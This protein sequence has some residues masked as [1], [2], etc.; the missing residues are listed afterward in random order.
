[1]VAYSFSEETAVITCFTNSFFTAVT[2]SQYIFYAS[3]EYSTSL[4]REEFTQF[5]KE[6]NSVILVAAMSHRLPVPHCHCHQLFQLV[7]GR[8]SS[9]FHREEL[10]DIFKFVIQEL[11]GI[12]KGMS[13]VSYQKSFQRVFSYADNTRSSTLRETLSNFRENFN[14]GFCHRLADAF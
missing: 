1:M 9:A 2:F 3:S 6:V 12:A 13:F 4:H 8:M 10:S 5:T 14:S 11:Q 7:V